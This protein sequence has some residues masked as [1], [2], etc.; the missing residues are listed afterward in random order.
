[1]FTILS[2]KTCFFEINHSKNLRI[3]T[4]IKGQNHKHQIEGKFKIQY[5]ILYTLTMNL[6]THFI[7]SLY[8]VNSLRPRA[9]Q[10][11]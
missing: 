4:V 1:M 2:N 9:K 6:E 7:W 10:I 8:I 3:I 5:T 11:T